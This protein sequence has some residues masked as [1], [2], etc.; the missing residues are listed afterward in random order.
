VG[1]TLAMEGCLERYTVDF[2]ARRIKGVWDV[3][4]I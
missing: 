3:Q 4:A 1:E 2:I